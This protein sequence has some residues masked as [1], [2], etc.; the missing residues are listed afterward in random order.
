MFHVEQNLTNEIVTLLLQADLHP[1]AIAEKLG[2]NHMTVARK[3]HTLVEENVADY[4]AEGKNKVYFLKK[5][6]VGRNAAMTAEIYRQSRIISRYPVLRGI[7]KSVREMPTIRLALLFGSYAKG[8]ATSTSDID[9]YV[10]TLDREVK[11]QLESG[12][13]SLSVKIGAFD[14]ASPLIREIMKDHVIIRGV[15]EYFDK[16]EIPAK[17]AKG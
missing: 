8:R 6:I 14:T 12:N 13:S 5:S 15:E 4:R 9:I 3:L 10:E 2:S 1:R 17:S 16:T 11:K 7:F